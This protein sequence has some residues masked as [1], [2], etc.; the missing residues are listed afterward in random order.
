MKRF[1]AVLLAGGC[2]SRMGR[3]KVLLDYRGIPL[4]RFQLEKLIRLD[5]NQL[6]VSVP[7]T[8]VLPAGP[9]T[10]VHDHSAQRGPLAGL[11]AALRLTREELLLTL[12]VDMPAITGDFLTSLLQKAGTR[13]LVPR[14]EGFYHG[15]C[16]IY[17]ARILPLVQQVL[18]SSDRSFQHLV[19]EALSM[20]L[21][22]VEEIQQEKKWLFE[23]W[24]SPQDLERASSSVGPSLC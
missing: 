22:E 13:G 5:L 6:F 20:E 15:T 23:N 14:L 12:A 18:S 2:S 1:A 11:E 19:Q 10:I 7:A 24:N 3:S 17:P 16:A 21:M 9:W 8:F 4:W